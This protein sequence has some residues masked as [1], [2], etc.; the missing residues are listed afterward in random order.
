MV[1]VYYIATHFMEGAKNHHFPTRQRLFE[2]LDNHNEKLRL[3]Q[4]VFCTKE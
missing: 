2:T 3:R 1:S 4:N